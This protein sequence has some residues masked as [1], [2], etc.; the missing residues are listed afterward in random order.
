MEKSVTCFQF[1][2]VGAVLGIKKASVEY[3]KTIGSF[4]WWKS[5]NKHS[6]NW[7]VI[8]PIWTLKKTIQ[9][10]PW[11]VDASIIFETNSPRSKQCPVRISQHSKD[12]KCENKLATTI[13]KSK[14]ILG[15]TVKLNKLFQ[16]TQK[17]KKIF[18]IGHYTFPFKFYCPFLRFQCVI[19]SL[20]Y[21][22]FS[23]TNMKRK[24]V[25]S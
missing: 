10:M 7:C 21:T 24:H 17:R 14:Q 23:T 11:N 19:S 13:N 6:P 5:S 15:L 2:W 8:K 1:K 25:H 4:Y 20:V 16:I 3:Y 9:L 18:S 22:C 12:V